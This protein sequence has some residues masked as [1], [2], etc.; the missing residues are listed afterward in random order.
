MHVCQNTSHAEETSQF[1]AASSICLHGRHNVKQALWGCDLHA[2]AGS[3]H[4]WHDLTRKWEE[5]CPPPFLCSCA[6]GLIRPQGYP[7]DIMCT[8]IETGNLH[9]SS[10]PHSASTFTLACCRQAQFFP[11]QIALACVCAR[12]VKLFVEHCWVPLCAAGAGSQRV[13]HLC[14]HTHPPHLQQAPQTLA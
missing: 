1:S 14:H 11:A 8:C 12:G 2:P 6:G 3:V 13:S 9:Q 7:E 10:N 4:Y 5:R